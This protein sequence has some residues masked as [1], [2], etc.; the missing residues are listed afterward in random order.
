MERVFLVRL[1]MLA[2]Y[3]DP[4][5]I[6]RC[7]KGK[8]IITGLSF[9]RYLN[10]TNIETLYKVSEHFRDIINTRDMVRQPALARM[11]HHIH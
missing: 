11:Y 9:V 2:T 7:R 5:L 6:Y 8:M 3:M 4:D 1:I 10:V